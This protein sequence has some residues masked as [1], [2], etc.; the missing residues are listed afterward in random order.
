MLKAM[1]IS[2]TWYFPNFAALKVKGDSTFQF[3]AYESPNGGINYCPCWN[4][5]G[6]SYGEVD[7]LGCCVYGT[8]IW[9]H[10]KGSSDVSQP[11]YQL[12]RYVKLDDVLQNPDMKITIQSGL[13]NQ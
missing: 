12:M 2:G 7:V 6:T 9:L 1:C 8:D 13:F 5:T 3:P 4:T 10:I 11:D